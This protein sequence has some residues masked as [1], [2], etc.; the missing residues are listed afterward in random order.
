MQFVCGQCGRRFDVDRPEAG[1]R[2]IC[3][4]CA[5]PVPVPPPE[6]ELRDRG[7]SVGLPQRTGGFAAEA[8]RAL[9]RK[10]YVVCGNCGKSLMVPGRLTGKTRRCPSCGHSILIPL[11]EGLELVSEEPAGA[12]EDIDT[13]ARDREDEDRI[14]E[15]Q[16]RDI[17]G[18]PTARSAPAVAG[19][20]PAGDVARDAAS[21]SARGEPVEPAR[22]EPVGPAR[23][24][25]RTRWLRR[26]VV[27]VVGL[28][29]LAAVGAVLY[30]RF[31]PAD[32]D[33]PDGPPKLAAGGGSNV[34]TGAQPTT[35]R[36]VAPPPPPKSVPPRYRAV[37]AA[38]EV[39][40]VGGYYPAAHDRAWWKLDVRITAGSDPLS[41]N[42]AGPDV[43]LMVGGK[44]IESLGAPG[45]GGLLPSRSTP[46]RASLEPDET[47]PFKFLFDVPQALRSASLRIAG[48]RPTTVS[49]SG[50]AVQPGKDGLEGVYDE[51]L[52]RNLRPLLRNPVMAAIQSAPGREVIIKRR[53]RLL[54]VFMPDAGVLGPAE[55]VA[56][57]VYNVFLNYRSDTIK[58]R[59]RLFDSGR[60]LILYLSDQ[61][62][63]QL[64]FRR[65]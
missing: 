55:P 35:T 10:V 14:V 23:K 64:T 38:A 13:A 26:A 2:V 30:S 58:C 51:Q 49:P 17:R 65:R 54:Q 46:G 24:S 12:T 7:L 27:A 56:A 25:K 33:P 1:G 9:G 32:T 61:P 45:G 20:G 22:G 57:G 11:P 6:A 15:S 36:Q 8:R 44:P 42:T 5:H 29:L 52:P 48:L 47:G 28:T 39:F 18:V 21:K 37:A 53:G 62:F 16:R 34:P 63:H 43:T 3:P 31:A 41:F 59:L 40:A 60:G 19:P 4:K 50:A